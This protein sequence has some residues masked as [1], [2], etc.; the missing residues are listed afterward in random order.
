MAGYK[1]AYR[2]ETS[3]AVSLIC[4]LLHERAYAGISVLDEVY[5]VVLYAMETRW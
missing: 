1:N 5:Q 4:L 3:I 2:D